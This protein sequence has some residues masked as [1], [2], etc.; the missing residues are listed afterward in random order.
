MRFLATGVD[1]P[2]ALRSH[3]WL[4]GKT[5][6]DEG[7]V[8][9]DSPLKVYSSEDPPKTAFVAVRHHDY[10]YYIKATDQESKQA[11]S[12]LTYLFQLQ[13]PKAPTQGPVL[14][15]PTG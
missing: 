6:L 7:A 13:S 8:A 1:V 10:W 12:L 3:S 4:P 9:V 14:T 11:F 15:V 2:T 5:A